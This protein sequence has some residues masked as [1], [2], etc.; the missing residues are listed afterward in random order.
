MHLVQRISSFSGLGEIICS[1]TEGHTRFTVP[2]QPESDVTAYLNKAME[3]AEQENAWF[4]GDQLL[5]A[6]TYWGKI[7]DKQILEDW[8]ERYEPK[9]SGTRRP[10]RVGV[11]MAGNIPMVGFHDLLSVLI[12]GNHLIARLSSQDSKLIPAVIQLLVKVE[13]AWAE[14]I[15]L[16]TGEIKK[17][18]AIIATGSNNTSRY[19]SYYFGKVP[20]IIRK[21]RSG[22]AVLDGTE[23]IEELEGIASDIF[24]FFGL[25]CRNVSKLYLPEGYEPKPLYESFL[26]YQNLFHH[27]KYRN[28]LDYYKSLYLVNRTRFLDGIFY[29]LI[30]AEQITTPVSVLHFEYYSDLSLVDAALARQEDQIQCI[31]SGNPHLKKKFSK[32]VIDPGETQNP[33][34][35]D[36]ADGV[37][38][39]GF[40]LE[41]I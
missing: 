20:H 12:T 15:E 38:T 24:S 11:V 8:L 13:P 16:T 6:L 23:T 21:N 30:E 14:Q 10:K 26:K 2:D 19:F 29:L 37:D 7:L 27:P 32:K 40:L 25:G 39:I 31:V 28:N 35:S 3:E 33:S 41:K 17:P 34:L 9:I 4:T 5:R 36:Y 1:F 22:V 18:D